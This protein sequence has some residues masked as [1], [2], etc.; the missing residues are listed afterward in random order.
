M[1]SDHIHCLPNFSLSMLEAELHVY[2][3]CTVLNSCLLEFVQVLCMLEHLLW[4]HVCHY[5]VLYLSLNYVNHLLQKEPSLMKIE[6]Y[7]LIPIPLERHSPWYGTL[8]ILLKSMASMSASSKRYK[9][10]HW[11]LMMT[12]EMKH[13]IFVKVWLVSISTNLPVNFI[14][15]FS[16]TDE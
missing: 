8:S 11:K 6:R 15:S 10:E 1:Y 5:T 7:L 16:L 9:C 4:V 3:M 12:N 2:P 14:V 13:A